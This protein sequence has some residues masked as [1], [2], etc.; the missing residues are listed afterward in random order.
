MKK[1][2][3]RIEDFDGVARFIDVLNRPVNNVFRSETL[4]SNTSDA[5]F[6]GT[7]S[8]KESEDIMSRGYEDGLK[9]LK[10]KRGQFQAAS[11][12]VKSVP[13][14]SVV[15]YAPNVPNA[16]M[17]RPDTMIS[18]ERVKMKSKIVR[19]MYDC[20]ADCGISTDRFVKA[21]RNIMDLVMM[22]ELQGYRVQL[23]LCLCFCTSKEK[24]LCRVKVKDY[25]QALNPLKISYPLI[26]PSFFRRQGFRWLETTPEISDCG[27]IRGY[28]RPLIYSNPV[29]ENTEGCRK[30]MEQEGILP[31]GFFFTNFYEAEKYTGEDLAK[32]MKIKK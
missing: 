22:L 31:E 5:S 11:N 13:R 14:T 18:A 17:G 2:K 26:H 23:D 9:D 24:A 7:K 28:G 30:F 32:R 12:D 19:I 27:F 21:G 10:A 20:G 15:G 4:S 3:F 8:Y 1:G 25:R 29:S 16:I 6:T